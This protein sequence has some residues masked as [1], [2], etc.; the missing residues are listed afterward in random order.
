MDVRT[1]LEQGQAYIDSII[2]NHKHAANEGSA[3]AARLSDPPNLTD[4]GNAAR[5]RAIHGENIRYCWQW[6][7]WIVW[8]GKRWEVD[9]GAAAMRLCRDI[10]KRILLEASVMDDDTQRKSWTKGALKAESK[11]AL[12]AAL[13]LLKSEE[14]IPIAVDDLD[15]N[16]W[17]LNVDNG[18]IDLK[19]GALL[20]HDR[21]Q[22]LTKLCPIQ[23]D[24]KAI[25]PTWVSFLEQI[26]GGDQDLIRF[27]QKAF[28][29][30]LTGSVREQ[31]FFILH[32][33]GRNGK[34]TLLNVLLQL[35]GKSLGVKAAPGVLMAKSGSSH[36]TELAM[37]CG[38]RVAVCIETNDRRSFDEALVKELT[39]GDRITARYMRKDFF[40]FDPTHK[41]WLATN[42]KPIVT[43]ND[44]GIWRR[45]RLIPFNV[46][47][48]DD[49]VDKR[50]A[51]KLEAELPGI[52]TWAVE[53][54]LAWQSD[55]LEPPQSV[56]SATG[57]YREEMDKIGNFISECCVIDK[58]AQVKVDDLYKAYSEWCDDAGER[59]E[60]KRKLTLSLVE[61]G[62]K[63]KRTM[64][65]R[66][67]EGIGLSA[68]DANDTYDR[69]FCMNGLVNEVRK[70]NKNYPSYVSYPSYK[71]E[72]I[73]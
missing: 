35:L 31:V 25:C 57:Q 44:L 9:P 14:G 13:E 17:L 60:S 34:S 2:S 46:V 62:F 11:R 4:I 53:G 29:Y 47:I 21:S 12:D 6:S 66:F 15:G 73:F 61:R 32:G 71:D 59:A 39:G 52:L 27:V 67:Y 49:Q 5:L 38:V 41:L 30:S 24:Q 63:S 65:S 56:V 26:F 28:G 58:R 1:T 10:P 55:G 43:G 51:E 48:P 36:P 19:T 20:K 40:E 68:N 42:H 22:Y 64:I 69:D 8:T 33:V 50:L 7:S 70:E 16:H 37:L 3:P 18:M 23:H 54:C 72:I 45:I